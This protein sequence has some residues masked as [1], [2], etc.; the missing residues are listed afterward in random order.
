MK[1]VSVTIITYNEEANIVRCLESLSWADE[2]VVLDSFSTDRTPELCRKH[3]SKVYQEPWQGYGRQ[4]NLCADKASHR[5]IL[6]VDA[7]EVVT[8]E[9]AREILEE[10]ARGPRRSLYALPRKNFFG[11]RW[12]RFGGWYPDMILRLYDKSRVRFSELPVHERLTPDA[13]AGCFN[14]PLL[15]YSYQGMEDYVAR[16]NRYSSL[17]AQD[18][19]RQGERAT[20]PDLLFRPPLSFVKN[21]VIK[22]G[23][24]EGFLGLFLAVVGAFYTFMK[25]AKTRSV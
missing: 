8:A 10:L 21:F 15:H 24:R 5:W 4:K 19:V 20:W 22:Q 9:S 14:A 16:Q 17:Y 3:T 13:D 11:D 25:Y 12:V 7:D 1:K 18:L 2:I 23:F 6:N